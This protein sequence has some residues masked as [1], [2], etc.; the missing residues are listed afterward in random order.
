MIQA[1]SCIFEGCFGRIFDEFGRVLGGFGPTVGSSGG[2]GGQFVRAEHIFG[3][4]GASCFILT[5]PLHPAGA[6]LPAGCP[7]TTP[8]ERRPPPF[9][10]R[11]SGRG[12]LAF[13]TGFLIGSD[14]PGIFFSRSMLTSFLSPDPRKKTTI[15]RQADE[16]SGQTDCF[17][18]TITTVTNVKGSSGQTREFQDSTQLSIG[19]QDFLIRQ[20][21]DNP[22]GGL[23]KTTITIT[24]RDVAVNPHL[25]PEDFAH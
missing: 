19:K 9:E 2:A 3:G 11:P 18:I 10:R 8:G 20:W 13:G 1:D 6:Q 5:R 21:R 16:K 23:G 25:S 12:A 14:V 4:I 24:H 7:G 17:I 15:S 22:S